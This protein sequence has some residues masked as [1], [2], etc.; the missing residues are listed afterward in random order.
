MYKLTEPHSSPE[1]GGN[2]PK[3]VGQPP[4]KYRRRRRKD[5]KK[6]DIHFREAISSALE[7]SAAKMFVTVKAGM[8]ETWNIRVEPSDTIENLKAK[9]HDKGGIPPGRCRITTLHDHD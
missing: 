6:Q 4:L 9:I 1:G 7:R 3:V 2:A 5:K 8:G